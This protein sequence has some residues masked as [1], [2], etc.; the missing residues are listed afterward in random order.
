[1]NKLKAVLFGLLFGL[2]GC[3]VYTEK[4]SEAVSENVYAANDS[5][6]KARIDL[7]QFYSNETTKFIK[8]PKNPIKI[9]SIYKKTEDK[10][11]SQRVVIVPRDYDNQESIAI[12]SEKYNELLKDS[13]IKK[14]LE[15]DNATK[16]SQLQKN[17]Q[18]LV[19]QKEMSDKMV[20]DLNILQKKL[21]EKDLAILWRNI[22]IAILSLLIAAFIYIKVSRPGLI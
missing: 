8:P 1:M 12:G 5:L 7:A 9:D 2:S 17:N 21:L 3:T 15:Q 20:K 22:I 4:Q 19:K 14:Q 13:Q 16:E 10:K 18:E 11:S 6:S